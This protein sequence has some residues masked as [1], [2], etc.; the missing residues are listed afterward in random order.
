MKKY[1][2]GARPA[3]AVGVALTFGWGVMA[4]H[5]WAD[6]DRGRTAE[7]GGGVESRYENP[8]CG[9]RLKAERD[10]W[11]VELSAVSRMKRNGITA[12]MIKPGTRLTLTGH[13]HRKRPREMKA[14]RMVRDGRTFD[15][16]L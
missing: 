8:H 13:P 16:T 7:I 5:G 14:V 11:V 3:A 1:P 4:H 6:F 12:Q 15:L 9:V 10:E 2:S